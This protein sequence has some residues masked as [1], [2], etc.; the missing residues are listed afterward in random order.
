[1]LNRWQQ[2]HSHCID[3]TILVQD[4]AHV[5]V[6]MAIIFV[7][8]ASRPFQDVRPSSCASAPHYEQTYQML[9]VPPC[10]TTCRSTFFKATLLSA[11]LLCFQLCPS[12]PHRPCCQMY[13]DL[14][15]YNQVLDRGW[16]PFYQ[17][18]YVMLQW[19]QI[20]ITELS[21]S[22]T[23]VQGTCSRGE[24]ISHLSAKL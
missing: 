1:M 19:M 10:K 2:P 11:S 7:C 3:F 5:D 18:L 6:I 16:L 23:I 9:R 8:C 17:C 14:T 20:L 4:G 13:T 12:S 21:I 15:I 24:S 22:E